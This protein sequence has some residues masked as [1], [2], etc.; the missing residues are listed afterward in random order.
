[1]DKAMVETVVAVATTG[2][3]LLEE[4]DY[5]PATK[6]QKSHRGG[7][8]SQRRHF[9][10]NEALQ[11]IRRDYIGIPELPHTPLFGAEFKLM[12]RI[13]RPRFQRLLEDVMAKEI[14]FYQDK[15][16]RGVQASLYAKL[17]LPLKSYAYGVPPPT[18]SLTTSRCPGPL[19][20]LAVAS[21][22]RQ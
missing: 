20:G 6:L 9:H 1:M 19:L 8:R 18:P 13:S 2:R 17:M 15:P 11:A 22:T 16:N 12:F 21:L 4:L 7:P 3:L 10:H 5:R 14:R